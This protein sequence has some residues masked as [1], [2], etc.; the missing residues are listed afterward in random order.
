MREEEITRSLLTSANDVETR[1]NNIL[2]FSSLRRES[3]NQKRESNNIRREQRTLLGE[4]SECEVNEKKEENYLN[5]VVLDS[6]KKDASR[7]FDVMTFELQ[8]S[9]NLCYSSSS[10]FTTFHY[11]SLSYSISRFN[12]PIRNRNECVS[13]SFLVFA[14]IHNTH[15]CVDILCKE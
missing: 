3:A 14:L 1:R 9:G 15:L 11:Q 7:C 12:I 8:R 6:E 13:L 10:L 2:C 5:K 4:E